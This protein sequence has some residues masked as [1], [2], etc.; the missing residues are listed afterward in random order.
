MNDIHNICHRGGE[1]SRPTNLV[2][3]NKILEKYIDID[4]VELDVLYENDGFLINHDYNRGGGDT[5]ETYITTLINKDKKIWL[6]IKD[7]EINVLPICPSFD[8]DKFDKYLC[9]INKKIKITDHVFIGCQ[10]TELYNKLKKSPFIKNNIKIIYDAVSI[11]YYVPF[12]LLGALNIQDISIRNVYTD[13]IDKFIYDDI[14]NDLN[15]TDIIAI[16]RLFFSTQ[17]DLEQFIDKI[18]A[19]NKYNFI[20]IYTYD[21]GFKPNLVIKDKKVKLIYLYN[22]TL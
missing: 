5:V 16:D 3:M 14:C 19:L 18:T 6:D 10:F 4:M 8:Y 20:I 13:F 9:E 1:S 22:Y 2:T 7:R 12:V 11:K 15:N 17:C 21:Y